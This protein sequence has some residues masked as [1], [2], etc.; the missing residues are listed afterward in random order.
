M[1]KYNI[2]NTQILLQPEDKSDDPR[3]L[4]TIKWWFYFNNKNNVEKCERVM[5]PGN[6]TLCNTSNIHKHSYI[7]VKES[8]L[9]MI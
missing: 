8:K 4:I 3:K 6:S 7:Y 9:Q 5:P 1:F 2:L